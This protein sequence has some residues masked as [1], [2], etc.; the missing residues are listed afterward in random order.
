MMLC[1]SAWKGVARRRAPRL[2]TQKSESRH[3]NRHQ[4]EEPCVGCPPE[5][6]REPGKGRTAQTSNGPQSRDWEG[7][8]AET[9]PRN[10]DWQLHGS[11]TH[12]AMSKVGVGGSGMR[13]MGFKRAPTLR[14]LTSSPSATRVL[15]SPPCSCSAA[16]RTATAVAAANLH[17]GAI[18]PY[19][20]PHAGSGHG[21][22]PTNCDQD[23]DAVPQRHETTPVPMQSPGTPAKFR[24]SQRG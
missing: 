4:P 9:A 18:A 10:R 5:V 21:P 24:T 11:V 1:A 20:M 23:A 8:R 15:C 2:M 22:Q 12:W 19:L 13:F 14:A 6:W 17:H 3:C 16:G 7:C